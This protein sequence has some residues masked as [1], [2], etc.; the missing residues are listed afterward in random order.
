M[1]RDSWHWSEAGDGG[2]VSLYLP[3]RNRQ[4]ACSTNSIEGCEDPSSC[5]RTASLGRNNANDAV[6]VGHHILHATEVESVASHLAVLIKATRDLFD[7]TT[8]TGAETQNPRT[9]P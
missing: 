7:V 3:K 9:G 8:E 4:D 5:E 6:P 2:A 1:C